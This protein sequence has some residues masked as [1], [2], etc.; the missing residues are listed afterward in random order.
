MVAVGLVVRALI[1][2]A[3]LV[4]AGRSFEAAAQPAVTTLSGVVI[5]VSDGDTLWLRP[6]PD[7]DVQAER[8][9]PVKIRLLGLDAPEICQDQGPEARAALASWILGRHVTV[10]R[11]AV[12]NYGRQLATLWLDGQDVGAR[13]VA[14]GQAWSARWHGAVGSYAD[15]EAVARHARAGLFARPDPEL[16]RAFRQ[17]HGPCR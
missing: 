17:R 11:R 7:A 2:A 15:E 8:R 1:L 9:K 13:L 12:D 3:L 14:Q 4:A 16:P 5:R 10:Q 6:D